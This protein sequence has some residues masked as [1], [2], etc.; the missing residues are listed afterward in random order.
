MLFSLSQWSNAFLY[1]FEVFNPAADDDKEKRHS[2]VPKEGP[3]TLTNAA[4]SNAP[5][6]REEHAITVAVHGPGCSGLV[7]QQQLKG[8]AILF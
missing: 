3:Q 1:V 2:G 7:C 6:Q 8:I 4:R 5:A